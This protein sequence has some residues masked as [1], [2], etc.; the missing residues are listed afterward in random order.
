MTNIALIIG[1]PFAGSFSHALAAEYQRAAEAA[2]AT[3]RLIDLAEQTFPITPNELNE[4]R[5]RGIAGVAALGEPIDAMVHTMEWA[6]H[7]V[8]VYPVWWGTFPAVLKGFIDR[9]VLSGVAFRYGSSPTN[10]Q[11]LWK[12]KTARIITTGDAPSWWHSTVY[13]G[14]GENALK[15]ATLWYVGVRTIGITRFT[16]VKTSTPARRAQ[17]LRRAHRLGARDASQAARR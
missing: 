12:G 1:H 16:T 14:P 7:F 13:R 10:W 11:K 2:G 8:F 9:V 3:V 17:W 6:N 4:V 5:V 15:R